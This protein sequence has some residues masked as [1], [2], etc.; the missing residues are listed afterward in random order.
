M[1]AISAIRSLGALLA[2]ALMVVACGGE[3]SLTPEQYRAQADEICRA[4][5]AQLRAIPD[6]ILPE[7]ILPTLQAAQPLADEQ[8]DQLRA[9]AAPEDLS[10]DHDAALDLLERQADA[11]RAAIGELGGGGS[12]ADVVDALIPRL[13]ALD[14]RADRAARRLGLSVCGEPSDRLV[15]QPPPTEEAQ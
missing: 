6:P 10:I 1:R 3:S 11:T 12:T 14:R 4:T 13:D 9:L 7:D 15:D 5:T 8:L 2:T